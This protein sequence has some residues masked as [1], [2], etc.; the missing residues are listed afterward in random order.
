[1]EKNQL[2][3]D[4]G[5]I[6]RVLAIEE[7]SV[8]MIDCLKRTMPNWYDI[9]EVRGYGDCTE[10]ELLEVTGTVLLEEENL[11]SKARKTVHERF[12]V[13]AGILPFIADDRFRTEAIRRV[14]E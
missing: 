2:L 14:A 7:D 5:C 6:Y 3:K 12:T 9:D 4:N 11:S 10:K 8:L 13:V 1:M